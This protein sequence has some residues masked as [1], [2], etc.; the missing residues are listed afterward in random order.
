MAS[1]VTQRYHY[2]QTQKG[3]GDL[4]VEE[5]HF[6]ISRGGIQFLKSPTTDEIP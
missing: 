1:E 4:Q 6:I 5:Q 3:A 2:T